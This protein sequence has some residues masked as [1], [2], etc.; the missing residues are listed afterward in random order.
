[1]ACVLTR[2]GPCSPQYWNEEPANARWIVEEVFWKR[3]V[4]WPVF[5]E[6][7]R[8]FQSSGEA[9]G[10]ERVPRIDGD[11]F[12]LYR[13]LKG[14]Q[15]MRR[16][17]ATPVV[18]SIEDAA[19]NHMLK[20]F[21]AV[22]QVHADGVY[23]DEP[24][25]VPGFRF[26][27]GPQ[28]TEQLRLVETLL[29]T[30][31]SQASFSTVDGPL[32][33]V[34]CRSKKELVV[35]S[36][37]R[38]INYS[39]IGQII[40]FTQGQ[41]CVGPHGTAC[42]GH[43]RSAIIDDGVRHRKS[44]K[45]EREVKV[46]KR[47]PLV[48]SD[49]NPRRVQEMGRSFGKGNGSMDIGRRFDVG[50][51][52]VTAPQKNISFD[53]DPFL[54]EFDEILEKDTRVNS[55]MPSSGGMVKPT[56]PPSW[57]PSQL[58]N[59]GEFKSTF[60]KENFQF[61]AHPTI[62][63][64]QLY[65]NLL[66]AYLHRPVEEFFDALEKYFRG[67]LET[68]RNTM[69][70][71]PP[72]A[73][74]RNVLLRRWEYSRLL[75]KRNEQ[76]FPKS[77]H[78]LLQEL[79][80]GIFAYWDIL[81]EFNKDKQPTDESVWR[82]SQP[83][84][85]IVQDY[86]QTEDFHKGECGNGMKRL[87][88]AHDIILAAGHVAIPRE[89][90]VIQKE[91]IIDWYRRTLPRP[92]TKD[93]PGTTIFSKD[94][95]IYDTVFLNHMH[96]PPGD[97]CTAL[98]DQFLRLEY[99]VDPAQPTLQ[100]YYDGGIIIT[101][102]HVFDDILGISTEHGASRDVWIEALKNSMYTA[103]INVHS[104]Q[105]DR[106]HYCLF[107]IRNARNGPRSIEIL[108]PLK[109]PNLEDNVRRFVNTIFGNDGVDS[110]YIH[111]PLEY[112]GRELYGWRMLLNLQIL[113]EMDDQKA[114][115]SPELLSMIKPEPNEKNKLERRKQNIWVKMNK[116]LHNDPLIIGHRRFHMFPGVDTI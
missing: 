89:P 29:D 68:A 25:N 26:L 32:R 91:S 38:Y 95:N 86:T 28:A 42:V 76:L 31:H 111:V 33:F 108:D 55:T 83:L 46:H 2:Y 63:L 59:D 97:I 40:A 62:A 71:Q 19:A 85:Q 116:H 41:R 82:F 15:H 115:M 21:L 78:P 1:M 112:T 88:A 5:N 113:L 100:M 24:R 14:M 35:D 37:Q 87:L 36:G 64:S 81:E 49:V 80:D 96:N 6:T 75:G 43:K 77:L 53:A 18:F 54:A 22:A 30:C 57:D 58:V 92:C 93:P 27:L 9:L 48:W 106:D 3:T 52:T 114:K 39:G 110:E 45:D 44:L 47:D 65:V 105:N 107:V 79:R 17:Q 50:D 69:R 74:L 109:A 13:H 20:I 66:V 84:L 12:H 98:V 8:M 67:P 103:Y 51:Q 94:V 23:T 73:F 61:S 99:A 56:T 10:V 102:T 104:T 11:H 34:R 90:N 72:N 101:P 60:A 4:A 7:M 70:L 16:G